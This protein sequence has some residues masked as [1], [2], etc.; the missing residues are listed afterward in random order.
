M[1]LYGIWDGRTTK[2]LTGRAVRPGLMCAMEGIPRL[3]I[4]ES[5]AQTALDLYLKLTK[6]DPSFY[7]IVPCNLQEPI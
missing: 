7:K 3:F 6:D 5:M 4:N 2:L 1:T